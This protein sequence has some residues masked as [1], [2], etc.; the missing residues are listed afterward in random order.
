[1]KPSFEA[2]L[3]E[4]TRAS[5]V[6]FQRREPRFPWAW[7]YHPEFELT[8]IRAG[9]GRR[10]VGDHADVYASG[11]LVLLGSNLPHT[12]ASAEGEVKNHA[13]VIQFRPEAIPESLLRLPEFHAVH[14]LLEGAG[15]GLR[16]PGANRS[17]RGSLLALPGKM[18]L[19]GWIGL[20][21]VLEHLSRDSRAWPLASA[22]YRH[23]R[24][25]RLH[26]RLEQ[27]T[28]HIEQNFRE[29][30]P[31]AEGARLC[32]LT[33]SAFSRFFRQM[34]GQTFVAFRNECRV[35]EAARLLVETD[36][37]ITHIAFECGFQNLANFNRRFREAQGET[38]GQY[39]RKRIRPA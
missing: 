5:L 35:R 14:V 21:E 39:R 16:F 2:P 38:P 37:T 19:Q 30:L 20:L 7:H 36:S 25:H 4:P 23:H 28:T 10:V 8:W 11:D 13:V 15:R 29:P 26:S 17:L 9:R 1:M 27:V 24:S 32:G 3:F 6:A 18:G 34:T 22:G 12:W 31:L 33:P